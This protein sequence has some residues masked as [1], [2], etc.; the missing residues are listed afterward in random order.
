[1]TDK[2]LDKLLDEYGENVGI[3]NYVEGIPVISTGALSIDVSTEVGGIPYG[4]FTEIYGPESGGKTTICLAIAAQAIKK[5][6]KVLYVD[7][8]NCLDY[9]YAHNLIGDF[10][11]EHLIIVQP[12]SAEDAFEIAEL[13]MENGFKLIIF[14]SVAAISPTKELEDTMRDQQVGLAARL[15]SKFLRKNAYAVRTHGVAFIFINQI[16]ASIGSYYGGFSTPAGYALKHYTSLRIY[17][18][19][20]KDIK[21][22]NEKGK[23]VKV[24]TFVNF[25]I[26]KNKVGTPFRQATT[27][28][29]YGK[30]IDYY[31]DVIAF[32]SLLGIIK[33]RGSY[34]AFEGEVI[35]NKPGIA[36]TAKAL[37]ELPEILDNV[38]KMCYNVLD[39]KNLSTKK[40]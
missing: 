33:S 39:V 3:T 30:G 38:I 16:R 20:G 21:V 28:I 26:K 36:N 31:R 37:E 25:I 22:K 4:R 1:M 9:R 14:D 27:N 8:E 5:G 2:L 32:A 35:G 15:V 11:E 6:D 29:I 24:G 7:M 19:K 17:I 23:E 34:Y 13:G 12:E 10:D 18:S 40:E